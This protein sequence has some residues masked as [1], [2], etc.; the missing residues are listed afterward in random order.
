SLI[1]LTV[2]NAHFLTR[3]TQRSIRCNGDQS[4]VPCH[5]RT[6]KNLSQFFYEPEGLTYSSSNLAAHLPWASNHDMVHVLLANY[7]RDSLCGLFVCRNC[8]QWMGKQL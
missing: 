2:S 1:V 8:L 6:R 5:D 4:I 7:S 3:V